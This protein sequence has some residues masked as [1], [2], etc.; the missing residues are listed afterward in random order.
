[1]LHNTSDTPMVLQAQ[2]ASPLQSLSHLG[3][4]WGGPTTRPLDG[5][6]QPCDGPLGGRDDEIDNERVINIQA[7][8]MNLNSLLTA[9]G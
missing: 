2:V 9:D 6:H 5:V 1:M 4:R 3:P 8:V 7:R